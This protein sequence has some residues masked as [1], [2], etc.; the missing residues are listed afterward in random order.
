MDRGSKTRY[1]QGV[2]VF[3]AEQECDPLTVLVCI[4]LALKLLFIGMMYLST[5]NSSI[6]CRGTLAIH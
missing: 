3:F 6:D 1:T 5:D 2:Q 4:N